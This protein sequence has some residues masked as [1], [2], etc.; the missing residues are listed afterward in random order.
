MKPLVLSAAGCGLALMINAILS[1]YYVVSSGAQSNNSNALRAMVAMNF[2]FSFF[3]TMTGIISWAYP[4]EVFPMEIRAKGNSL[5]TLTNW[6]LNL[7]FA[8]CAPIALK[9]M[10]FKFFY[11]FFA[12]NIVA[13]A[14]YF[15]FFPETNGKTLEQMDELFGDQLV[16]HALEDPEGAGAAIGEKFASLHIE[17]K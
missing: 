14:C 12:F 16:P 4:A 5:S 9:N 7:L 17:G 8:Q 13:C 11:F 3:Y 15:F 6:C 2:V 1:Q 10:G